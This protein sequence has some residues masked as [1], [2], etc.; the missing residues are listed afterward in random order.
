VRALVVHESMWGNTRR[1]AEAV[2]DA[3]AERM[4]VRV[5]DVSEVDAADAASYELVVVGAPTHAFSLSRP[6]T[7]TAAHEQ[8]APETASSTGL[9]E[10]IADLP[11]PTGAVLACFDTRADRVRK[12]PGSAARKA[13]RLLRHAG[14]TVVADE[15]FYVGDSPG[16]VLAGETERAAAWGRALA[17]RLTTDSP[18]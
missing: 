5:G 3:L 16:P 4:E 6:S 7:R 15:S 10:W 9:R 8:G 2:G 1:I 13:R 14:W 17:G 11:A 18:V 12:L